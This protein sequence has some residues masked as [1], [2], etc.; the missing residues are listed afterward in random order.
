MLFNKV[1]LVIERGEKIV[2][3]G[4]NGCGKSI[5]L[6]L[7]M[8]FEKFLRGEVILGEYNVLLNYFEQ[9]QVCFVIKKVFIRG[10]YEYG[11]YLVVGLQVEVLDLD[12]IVIE[13][14]VEVVVDWR[15][16]D[17]KGFFGCCNFKVDMFDRKVFFFEW[18]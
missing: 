10:D 18:W 15:I 1:N 16:D 11:F 12:K 8:G 13:M 14:V 4:L 5:L 7:I 3:I 6:K 17:I 2:I 9:N